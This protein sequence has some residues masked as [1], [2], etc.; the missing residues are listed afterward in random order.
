M[1]IAFLFKKFGKDAL[2]F[3]EIYLTLSMDLK[4]FPPNDAK[5][6]IAE[7]IKQKLLIKKGE[8]LYPNFHYRNIVIP[9]E[10]HPDKNL[11]LNLKDNHSKPSK[12]IVEIIADQLLQKN[13]DDYEKIMEKI[14]CK[15]EDMQITLDV[16]ALVIAKD[17][18]LPVDDLIKELEDTFFTD[19]IE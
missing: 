15:A 9:I 1:I 16:A 12:N 10:F 6:F 13:P 8:L 4:W 11:S 7:A 14:R 18:G 2:S 5:T 3:S 19:N 17:Y